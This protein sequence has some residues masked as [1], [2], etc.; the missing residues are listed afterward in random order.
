M[1]VKKSLKANL[2]AKKGLFAQ[3]GLIISIFFITGMFNI[4]QQDLDIEVIRSV[5]KDVIIE[6]PPI[7]VEDDIKPQITKI[8]APSIT[9][10]IEVVENTIEL[11]ETDIFNPET[12]EDT[13]NWSTLPKGI[14]NDG[15][16]LAPEDDVP[17]FKAEIAPTFGGNEGGSASENAFRRWVQQRVAYPLVFQESHITGAVSIKFV[18]GKDGKISDIKVLSSPDKL[19]SEEVIKVMKSSPAWT[20]GQQRDKP[21]SV[22]ATIR[23]LFL[24]K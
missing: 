1:E 20:P 19:L 16:I 21:V 24:I 17:V 18:I 14:P 4:S 22:H 5:V 9:D 15:S 13:P 8:V 6:Q 3:I 23:V 2:Q 10:K 7:T 12:D 11:E